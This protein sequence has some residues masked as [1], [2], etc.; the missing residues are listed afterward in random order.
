VKLAS[1][2]PN[3]R[4]LHALRFHFLI[5]PLPTPLAYY[6]YR[7]PTWF[8]DSLTALTL[9][10]ELIIPFFIFLPRRWRITAGLLFLALQLCILLTG[11]YAFFNLLTMCLCLWCFDNETYA[12]IALMLERTWPRQK[13]FG[14]VPARVA[15]GCLAFLMLAGLLQIEADVVPT[16]KRLVR[17]ITLVFQPFE[18]VNSYGLFAVMTTTR[19]EIILEGSDDQQH[20]TEYSFRYKPGDLHRSL[21]LVAPYQPRLDWQMWFAALGTYQENPW[22]A[23]LIFRLLL[24]EPSVTAL[25]DPQPFQ[26]PPKYI[27]AQLYSYTFSAPSERSATGLVWK[28]ELLGN[29]LATISL[30]AKP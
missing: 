29:W 24:N 4:N 26:K 25:L 30:P 12:P 14:G 9:A 22:V 8:L 5:Q 10:I 23:T 15:N 7:A 20:W 13:T 3:W 28:R 21:P 27:R 17:T 19:P 1:H 16:S 2:D 18:V 6:A 11:N